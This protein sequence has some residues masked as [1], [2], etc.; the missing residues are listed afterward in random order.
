[1]RSVLKKALG[2]D[3][4][5]ILLDRIL[6]SNEV[7]GIDNLRWMDTAAVA[8][9]MRDESPQIVAAILVHLESTQAS[10]V[11]KLLPE[12]HRNEVH[13]ADRHARRH[14]AGGAEGPERDHGQAARPTP[15][16]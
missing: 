3:K 13:G 12:R 1:M 6:Q 15:T 2:D 14:P 8:E 11:L 16:G 9:L 4:A 7:E 10:A 5:N